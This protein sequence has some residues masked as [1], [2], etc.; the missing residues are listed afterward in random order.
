MTPRRARRL[1]EAAALV[2]ALA[3]VI[4]VVSGALGCRIESAEKGDLKMSEEGLDKIVERVQ[5]ILALGRRGGTEAE[6]AAAMAKA[7]EMLER[8][9]LTMEAVE[10]GPTEREKVSQDTGMYLYQRRLWK[11]VAELNFC[12]CFAYVALGKYRGK[13]KLRNKTFVVGRKINARSTIAMASYLEGTINRLCRERLDV[14]TYYSTTSGNRHHQFFSSWGV[15]FREGCA[16]RLVEK[17]SERRRVALRRSQKEE[18]ERRKTATA[19]I[20]DATAVSLV[21][22]KDKETDANIDFLH[23]EGTSARWASERAE[24]AA[25]REREDREYAEWATA[26]P[27]EA[28][29]EQEKIRKQRVSYGR[30]DRQRNIDWGAYS[31]GQ[32]AAKDV[33]LDPQAGTTAASGRISRG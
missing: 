14:H 22:Y 25:E 16:D 5:K 17:L 30:S 27:E 28:R 32:A 33:G 15:S 19:G 4:A 1:A 21:V 20:S 23:G 11:S 3:L 26:N 18:L 2:A 10:R 6:S 12:L 31:A 8:H 29:R 9:N 13:P 24:R 7:Q